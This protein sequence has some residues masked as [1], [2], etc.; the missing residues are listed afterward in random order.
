MNLQDVLGYLEKEMPNNTVVKIFQPSKD[1]IVFIAPPKGAGFM[2][3]GSPNSYSMTKDRK[4]I[5]I[6]PI[7]NPADYKKLTDNRFLIYN[8]Y[9]F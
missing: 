1:F 9:G 8:K 6:N 5:P 2:R 3:N 4:I 7:E